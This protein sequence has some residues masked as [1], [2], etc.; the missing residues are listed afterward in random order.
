MLHNSDRY[1]GAI[2]YSKENTETERNVWAGPQV[3]PRQVK[4]LLLVPIKLLSQR[5]F[6]TIIFSPHPSHF[7]YLYSSSSFPFFIHSSSFFFSSVPTLHSLILS[8]FFFFI[9]VIKRNHDF[10]KKICTTKL[11]FYYFLYCCCTT[12]SQFPDTTDHVAQKSCDSM[13]QQ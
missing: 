12:K 4:G 1:R 10:V 11:R 7:P 5:Q 9:F 3:G 6:Q 2:G 13:V 8:D